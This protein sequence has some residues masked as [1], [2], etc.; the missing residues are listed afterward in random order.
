MF[1]YAISP[2]LQFCWPFLTR[3]S[4][5]QQTKPL[6]GSSTGFGSP[7]TTTT[8]TT[9][10]G[11]IE[12]KPLFGSSTTPAKT[13]GDVEPTKPAFGSGAKVDYTKPLFR[14]STTTTAGA[15]GIEAIPLFGAS[16]SG[17][18]VRTE[19]RSEATTSSIQRPILSPQF[20]PR[21]H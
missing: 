16:T 21:R 13:T 8:T 2:D 4:V 18:K 1:L 20:A 6:F 19:L 7:A 12:T 14:A 10:V 3:A 17:G 11:G 15:G 9:K 5:V